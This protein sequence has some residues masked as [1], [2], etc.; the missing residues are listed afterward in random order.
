MPTWLSKQWY[1]GKAKSQNQEWINKALLEKKVKWV[2]IW[3]PVYA[4]IAEKLASNCSFK[5]LTKFRK[6]VPL[7]IDWI[8]ILL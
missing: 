5:T 8:L 4:L 3:D 2:N 6:I 1:N 7:C